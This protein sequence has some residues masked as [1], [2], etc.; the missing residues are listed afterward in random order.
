MA[1]TAPATAADAK[2]NNGILQ[3]VLE[4]IWTP[5]TNTGLIK[6]MNYSFYSLFIVLFGMVFLTNFNLHVCALL[7]LSVGLFFSL[8]W[9][10]VQIQE[11]EAAQKKERDEK[12]QQEAALAK[13]SKAE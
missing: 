6:A 9:F 1:A 3:D 13:G 7:T 10:L 11:I 8:K 4:S 2:K 12:A 5:G